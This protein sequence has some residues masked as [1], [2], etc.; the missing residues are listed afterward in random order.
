MRV[1]PRVRHVQDARV[2]LLLEIPR[3]LQQG[4]SLFAHR[5]GEQGE[6]LSVVRPWVL[7]ARATLS[8]SACPS[9]RMHQLPVWVLSRG[10]QLQAG[11]YEIRYSTARRGQSWW[12]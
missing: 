10:T 2:L 1:S 3:M 6:G 9:G 8:A 11:P 5:P 4:V 7:P 12:W